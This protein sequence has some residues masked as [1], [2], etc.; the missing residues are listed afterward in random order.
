[1]LNMRPAKA[2]SG[3]SIGQHAYNLG[4][5]LGSLLSPRFNVALPKLGKEDKVIKGGE[6]PSISC[7][8]TGLQSTMEPSTP[9]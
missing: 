2:Y 6:M 5:N 4:K 9:V 8:I 3:C 7:H 1:F